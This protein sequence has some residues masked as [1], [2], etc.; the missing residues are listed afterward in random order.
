MPL[1]DYVDQPS[2]L[3]WTYG[4][5]VVLVKLEGGTHNAEIEDGSTKGKDCGL[6]PVLLGRFFLA[7]H[8]CVELLWGKVDVLALCLF[9]AFFEDFV[10]VAVGE[11]QVGVDHLDLGLLVFQPD[12]DVGHTDLVVVRA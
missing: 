4:L 5:V 10:K 6:L 12:K 1:P 7:L 8:H 9:V 11:E 3:S 2:H